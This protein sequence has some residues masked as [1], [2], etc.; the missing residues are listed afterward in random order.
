LLDRF[1]VVVRP[2]HDQASY[3]IRARRH[4][5]LTTNPPIKNGQLVR[6]QLQMDG[7]RRQSAAST[8]LHEFR[9]PVVPAR[10][11]QGDFKNERVG[12]L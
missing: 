6:R 3:C 8:R 11:W 9:Y 7:I 5:C 2:V 1:A 4:V 12:D 10:A